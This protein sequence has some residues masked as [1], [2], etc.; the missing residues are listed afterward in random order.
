VTI[1]PNTYKIKCASSLWK[2]SQKQKKCTKREKIEVL[3]NY[4]LLS[5]IHMSKLITF[6]SFGFLIS[7]FS[8][9]P[10]YFV[11]SGK[12]HVRVHGES[13]LVMGILRS[14]EMSIYYLFMYLYA[15]MMRFGLWNKRDFDNFVRQI[16][17]NYVIAFKV[18]ILVG[19]SLNISW[20]YIHC[21]NIA[22][23]YNVVTTLN[24]AFLFG[25]RLA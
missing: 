10:S 17:H 9:V 12:K 2:L 13:G 23:H 25:V 3:R 21:Y 24:Y 20:I 4:A 1:W 5:K 8:G 15:V 11:D 7:V 22:T 18:F 16:R 6:H 14:H 19:I